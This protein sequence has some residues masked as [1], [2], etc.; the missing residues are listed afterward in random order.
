MSD[1]WKRQAAAEAL[2]LVEPGMKLGLGSGS[3]AA[4]FVELLGQ[5][6]RAGL[7]IIGVPT[8][9]GTARLAEK[10]GIR[11]TT[12]DDEPV[13]D[14]TIDGAD[15]IDPQLR[16]IKGGGGAHLREKIVANSSSRLV[17]IADTSKKV[18]VLGKFPLP[19]EVVRFGLASTRSFI[20]ALISGLECEGPVTLRMAPSGQPFVTDSGNFILDAALGRIEEPDLL[21]DSLKLMPG[22]VEH[23]LFLDLADTAILGGP[24]GV[25]L[26][27]IDDEQD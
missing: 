13:L 16:L 10:A 21:A 4:I 19:I 7:D 24:N 5:K 11:L 23:G 12:L 14:L 22:V 15:E 6:V 9:E 27:T 25:E 26:V 8:S 2:K 20:E 17:I 3:T 18:E 1:D